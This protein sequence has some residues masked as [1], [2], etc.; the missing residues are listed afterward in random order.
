MFF[1]ATARIQKLHKSSAGE[2]GHF[3]Q[4]FYIVIFILKFPQILDFKERNYVQPLAC[5]F[6]TVVLPFEKTVMQ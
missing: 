1:L 6:I 2:E 3:F 4:G 5:S